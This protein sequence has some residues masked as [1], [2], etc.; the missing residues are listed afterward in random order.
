MLVFAETRQSSPTLCSQ[1]SELGPQ[2][3]ISS[4]S[5]IIC[6]VQNAFMV[7]LCALSWSDPKLMCKIRYKT[8]Y[9]VRPHQL[10][11]RYSLYVFVGALCTQET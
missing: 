5:Y 7:K 9:F 6:T 1:N 3:S 4:K 2:S 8:V 10:L 11:Y